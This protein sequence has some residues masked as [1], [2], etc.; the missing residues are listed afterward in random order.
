MSETSTA[1]ITISRLPAIEEHLK[2]LRESWEQRAAEA[3]TMV[4]TE[5]TVQSLKDLRAAMRKEFEEAD[6]QRKAAKKK[7]LE[8]WDQIEATFKDCITDAFKRADDSL[9]ATITGYENELKEKCK[10]EL[11]RYYKE[12]CAL[13]NIDFLSFEDAMRASGIKI[14]LSDAKRATP[15]QAM[16]QLGKFVS[17]VAIGMDQIS[18]MDDAPAIMAE[19]KKCLNVGQAV[20]VVQERKRREAAEIEAA[21]A[22]KRAQE[23]QAAAVAKVDAAAPERPVAPPQTAP[24]PKEDKIFPEFTFTVYNARRSQ[25]IKL[26]DFMKQEGINYNG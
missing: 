20:S 8:P 1:L 17:S 24:V 9:K 13:D 5:D 4:C 16:D 2:A 7:Y 14:G 10:A 6:T 15:R 26:R 12:L 21:E 18:Q 19:Y 11:E 23:E 3:A 22:R 25:L